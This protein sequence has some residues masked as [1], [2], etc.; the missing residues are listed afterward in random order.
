MLSP[1]RRSRAGPA[2]VI[3]IVA[4]I[5]TVAVLARFEARAG[6]P[7]SGG[8][9]WPPP[10]VGTVV[11]PFR[12][13]PC[14][15]CAGNRGIVYRVGDGARVRAV[16][17]GV[18]SWSGSVAG[19]RYVVVRH[20]DGRRVTYGRLDST[21]LRTGDRVVTGTLVGR[22]S[23]RFHFGLRSAAGHYV[24][25]A[26]LLGRSVRPPRLVPVDATPAR[27]G[28]RPILRCGGERPAVVH[29]LAPR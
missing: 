14:P 23:G 10:V 17:P 1:H 24:D 28:P 19:V 4:V 6:A 2:V 3:V 21:R 13:P 8:S 18:V 22:V 29:R 27:P 11:D 12:E 20:P 7:T 25:P 5:V 15:Y 26:P 16:A 9:C